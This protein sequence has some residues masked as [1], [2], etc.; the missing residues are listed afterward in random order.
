MEK[1]TGKTTFQKMKY[2]KLLKINCEGWGQ[3]VWD[4]GNIFLSNIYVLKIRLIGP[5][6]NEWQRKTNW[7]KLPEIPYYGTDDQFML[8][9]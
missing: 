1:S 5:K 3:N 7:M 6:V 2:I 4:I 8:G 9:T